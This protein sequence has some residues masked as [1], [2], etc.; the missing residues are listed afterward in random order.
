LLQFLADHTNFE[1]NVARF[2]ALPQ[3]L[4]LRRSQLLRAMSDI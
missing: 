3:A 2:D 4:K 1:E